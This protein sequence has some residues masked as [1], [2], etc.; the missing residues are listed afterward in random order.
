MNIK[1]LLSALLVGSS[2]TAS[3]VAAP[4][5][6]ERETI[7]AHISLLNTMDDMGINIQVNNPNI[8][9]NEKDT[10]GMWVGA[11]RLFVVCQEAIRKS[12]NPVYTGEIFVASDDDLDT[13]RHEAHHVLQ[14]CMDGT[15]DGALEHYLNPTALKDFLEY[16]PDDME[17]GIIDLYR[18]YNTPERVV[19]LELEAW[20]V[21]DMV[22]AEMI[23]EALIRECKV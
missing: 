6:N 17:Q 21:A 9:L 8:C 18:S 20:A 3:A 13:I 5:Y 2:L 15:I 23:E 1:A 11:N 16:Y 4:T 10:S 12:P 19:M 14:D 22:P 7:D